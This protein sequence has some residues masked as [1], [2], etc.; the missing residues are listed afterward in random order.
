MNLYALALGVIIG[1]L[2]LDNIALGIALG[3]SFGL[4]LNN[5]EKEQE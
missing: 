5:D 1:S 3:I 2:L 4:L